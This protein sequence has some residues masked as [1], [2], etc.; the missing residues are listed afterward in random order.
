MNRPELHTPFP[1]GGPPTAASGLRLADARVLVTGAGRGV[2]IHLVRTFLGVGAEVVGVHRTPSEELSQLEAVHPRLRTARGDL[3]D[4]D[5]VAEVY[6]AGVDGRPFTVAVNN[7]GGYGPTPIATTPRR[8]LDAV[9]EANL[10]TTWTSLRHAARTMAGADRGAGSIASVVNVASIAAARPSGGMAAYDAAKAAVVQLT[11]SAALELAAS[12][13]RVN[14]V[15]PGLIDRPDLED[16][17]PEGAAR[18]V[19]RCPLRRLVTARDVAHACL[20]LASP[21]SSF[22]TGQE[23]VVDGGTTLAPAY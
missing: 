16:E 23:L 20:F 3:L 5:F 11:R 4:D 7:A 10:V 12:G 17:W 1:I 9:V 19:Q 14:A 18:W 21:L 22:V 15:S 2:G 13:I 6:E 8:G